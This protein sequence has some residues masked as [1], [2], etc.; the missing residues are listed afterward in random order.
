M[1]FE[2]RKASRSGPRL[3]RGRVARALLVTGVMFLVG[4]SAAA[5]WLFPAVDDPTDVDFTDVPELT[6]M[7]FADAERWLGELR[8]VGVTRGRLHHPDIAEGAVVAQSRLP[9]QVARAGDTIGLTMS[10]GVET[11]VVPELR[12]LAGDEAAT[13][14][15][16]IGFDVDIVRSSSAARAGV[17]E[18]RPEPGTRM[19]LPALVEL[20]VSGGAAIV[21]VPDLRGRHVDDIESILAVAELRLGAVSYQVDAPEGPGRV[22]SQSPAP[23]SSLRGDGLVSVVVAGAPPDSVNADVTDDPD[24]ARSDTIRSGR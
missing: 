9:G 10:A 13:L 8:L 21:S 14:L 22:V 19:T 24:P 15:R 2:R 23:R 12:G 11:R 16:R 6:G 4:Y 5:Q 7:P 20:V 1:S 3:A 17:I 18:S